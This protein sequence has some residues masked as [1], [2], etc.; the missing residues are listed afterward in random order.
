MGGLGQFFLEAAAWLYDFW[1]WRIV[2]EW[3]QGVRLLGGRATKLLKFDNARRPFRGIHAFWPGIGEILVQ[4]T[5]IETPETDLQDFV[6]GEGTQWA[7]AVAVTFKIHDLRAYY[8]RVHD[9]DETILSEVKAAVA[10][11]G[12]GLSDAGMVHEL[13]DAALELAKGQ[14]RGWG[15][16]IKRVQPTTLTR[17]QQ[18][19]LVSDAPS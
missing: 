11:A 3:E 6:S 2:R 16:E 18:I 8:L 19:R 13:G 15:L 10:S 9:A 5:N 14:T 7:A 4:E 1:P 12:A 17:A